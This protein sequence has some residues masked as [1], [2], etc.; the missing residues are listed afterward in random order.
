V[1]LGQGLPL[2][3]EVAGEKSGITETQPDLSCLSDAR[4][5]AVQ[6][7]LLGRRLALLADLSPAD[8]FLKP[9]TTALLA[10]AKRVSLG[11]SHCHRGVEDWP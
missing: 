11:S 3:V 7:R 2:F 4:Q 8:D 6:E 10:A 1:A 5:T 9:V